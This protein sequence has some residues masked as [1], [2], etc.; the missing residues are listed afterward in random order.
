MASEENSQWERRTWPE[1]RRLAQEVPEAGFH[2][3]STSSITLFSCLI[4]SYLYFVSLFYLLHNTNSPHPAARVLRRHADLA[5]N[6][7][8]GDGLFQLNPWYREL[9]D[10]F[11]ELS[12]DQLPPGV[13]SGCEFTSVCIN[14]AVYLPWL[15]SQCSKLGAVFRRKTI[16]HISEAAG[17]HHTGKPADVV[18]NATG[19]LACKLGGVEDK[20]VYPIR[21]QIVLVRNEAKGLMPT[22]S[23]CDD[24]DDELVYVMQRALGGG[25]ILGGT[26][27]KGSWDP[28]PDPNIAIRIMKRAVETLPALTDGKGIEGLD[29]IRHGVGLRPGREGGVRIEKEVIEGLRV[30]HNYGHAGWGYQGSYGCAERV[31]ELVDEVLKEKGN[32]AV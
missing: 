3:Q 27:T 22:V 32:A 11:R 15:V 8:L 10:N 6:K 25:T 5:D 23:G 12:A 17:L 19:V 4:R 14:T 1:L 20:K 28:N 29:V 21:G 7:L 24:G 30:V 16:K 2:F 31:V 13:D 9:M 26:Y 18:V